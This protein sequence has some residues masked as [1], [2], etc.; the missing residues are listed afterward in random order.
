MYETNP[1]PRYRHA[2]YIDKS[3][4]INA[5]EAIKNS[6]SFIIGIIFGLAASSFLYEYLFSKYFSPCGP[7]SLLFVLLLQE[8]VDFMR[9]GYFEAAYQSSGAAIRIAM[10]ALPAA[11][12]LIFINF[13]TMLY[14]NL[15]FISIFKIS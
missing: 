5:S 15:I 2:E 10:N 13:I 9:A 7:Q 6:L 11:F 4:A 8:W 3:Q 14:N 1:Y 12:F